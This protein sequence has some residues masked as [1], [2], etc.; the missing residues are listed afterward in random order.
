MFKAGYACS[1]SSCIQPIVLSLIVSWVAFQEPRLQAQGE[2]TATGSQLMFVPPPAEGAISLGVYDSNGQLIKVL[3]KAAGIDSFKSGLNGLFVEWDRTDSAGHTVS[4]GKY[5]ARGVLIGNVKTAG[6][7]FHLNDWVDESDEPRIHQVLSSTLL[8]DSR[9]TVLADDSRRDLIVYDSKGKRLQR[10]QTPFPAHIVKT[11]GEN[12]LVYD[13][14]QAVVIDFATNSTLQLGSFS[15]ITD[16]D[17]F[18]GRGLVLEG[19]QARIIS[20][21]GLRSLKLPV[22]EVTH[23]A[24]PVGTM[25]VASEDGKLWKLENDSFLPVDAGESGQ[26][27]DMC[28]GNGQAVW[29]LI[30]SGP[31]KILR[32]INLSGKQLRE[33]ELPKDLQGITHVAAARD[34]DS[35]LFVTESPN[36]HQ[37]IGVRLQASNEKKSIWEKWFDRSLISFRYFDIKDH[38]V[39]PATSRTESAAVTIKPVNNPLEDTHQ[40]DFQL[41][42]KGDESGAWILTSDGLPLFPVCNTNAIKQTRWNSDGANGLKVYISDG[43]VVE[44]YHVTGLDNLYRFDAGSFD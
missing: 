19:N 15:E 10:F 12:V 17:Y 40:V 23:C 5:Y 41:V 39:V 1:W 2:E 38:D 13:Q 9:I 34:Q 21:K 29:L 4:K 33:I 20:E 22:D 25:V 6:I 36:T 44:E 11:C 31:T 8:N 30:K 43:V 26:L 27:L 7:A 28:A 37:V 14:A 3:K 35:L 42:V 16:A 24:I 18:E 32:E